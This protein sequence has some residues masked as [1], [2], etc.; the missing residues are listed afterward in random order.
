MLKNNQNPNPKFPGGDV[1][2][3]VNKVIFK[4]NFTQNF[5]K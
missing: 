5:T 1:I 3:G 2:H 4:N